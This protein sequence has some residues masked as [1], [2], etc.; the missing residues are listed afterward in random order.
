MTY[1]PRKFVAWCDIDSASSSLATEDAGA[2]ETT[3]RSVDAL[4]ATLERWKSLV[5]RNA[6]SR[7]AKST[8]EAVLT[9]NVIVVD[10][11]PVS[12]QLVVDYL[13][14][15]G[16][17]RCQATTHGAT[18]FDF[19]RS[20]RPDVLLIDLNMP[21][22]DWLELL[23][24]I[25]ADEML[26][27]V[28]TIV[29][30]DLDEVGFK[31]QALEL[32]AG[33]FLAKPLD[34]MELI[35][36]VRNA[37][38][39]KSHQDRL[40]HQARDLDRLVRE[41]TAELALSRL[42][43]IHCLGRAA[44]YRDNETGRHVV[45]VGR[46]VGVIAR[47]L[48]LEPH[49]V[50]LME[51][52]APL[53]DVG[54]IGIPDAILRK[55]GSLAVDEFRIMQSHCDLGLRIFN[56]ASENSTNELLEHPQLGL[57]FISQYVSPVLRMASSIASSHHERWDGTGYPRGTS[58]EEIPLEGRITA[59]A[60]VFDALS[61]KRAYKPAFPLEKCFQIMREGRGSHFD[62]RVLDAFFARLNEI[63]DIFREY[64][65]VEEDDHIDVSK[66]H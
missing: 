66:L 28:P 19:I 37:W 65:D 39:V 16:M 6:I 31:R 21:D 45:R 48:G 24:R 46:Y 29:L 15:A 11:D 22:M 36:R 55:P 34:P 7:A 33:D 38:A 10:D 60:D 49:L 42:E 44:E 12:A 50:E 5:D 9:P 62:P 35:P 3:T 47:Q 8:N 18:S 32:G 56:D 59:V 25:H 17:D 57:N 14:E 2:A 20:R 63:L 23:R 30:T 13:A 53:H 41:R 58:G 27:H 51:L 40:E 1:D 64:S 54:K 43:L 26:A 61:T 52:A 4:G